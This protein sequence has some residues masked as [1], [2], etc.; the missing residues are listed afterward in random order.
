[1][2]MIS[3]MT[4][5]RCL[6]LALLS[7]IC[8]F[9]AELAQKENSASSETIQFKPPIGWRNADDSA[10]PTHV[11]IMVVGKGESE[12]PPSISLATETYSGTLKQY[13]KVVKELNASKGNAWKDLGTIQTEAGQASLS[14]TDNKS[15]WGEIKMMH[16]ILKKN[17]TI[18]I[19]TAAALK[20]EFPKFYQEIFTA[21]RS[22]RFPSNED[23]NELSINL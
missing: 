21:L 8:S 18:Y 11:K 3:F 9:S 4:I 1:M 10:L 13:L 12:F 14:Q 7:P 17:G 5:I 15:Q 22:F 16:V 6:F 2:N 19:L 23:Q 20:D